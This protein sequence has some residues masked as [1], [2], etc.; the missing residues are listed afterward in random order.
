ME[1][2]SRVKQSRFEMGDRIGDG[3]GTRGMEMLMFAVKLIGAQLDVV[4]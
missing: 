1:W 3:E 2:S 4:G